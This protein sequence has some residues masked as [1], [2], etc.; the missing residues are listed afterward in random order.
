MSRIKLYFATNRKHEGKDRWHPRSYGKGFSSNGQ[1]NLRFG[2]IELSVNN[3]DVES[4]LTKTYK[5][6]RVGDGEGLAKYLTK[7]A[8]KGK[9]TAYK[10]TIDK[11]ISYEEVPSTIVFREIKAEMEKCSDVL[12]FVHGYNVDWYEAVGSALALEYSLNGKRK[13]PDD[14]D[15]KVVLFSWPSN[16][17]S[18]PYAAYWSDRNDAEQSGLAVGRAMMKLDK[19]FRWLHKEVSKKRE[20]H[21]KQDIHLLCH[22]MGN[23]VLQSALQKLAEEQPGVRLPRLFKHIFMCSADVDDNVLEPGEPMGRLHELALDV[24]VY[25][26]HGDVALHLSDK[27]KGNPD[28]LG[29]TGF[30]HGSLVHKKVH[31][32]DCAPIVGGFVEHS[33]YLWA[34]VNDDISET[35]DDLAFDQ[36]ARMRRKESEHSWVMI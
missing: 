3:R 25:H 20:H 14:K 11:E 24:S 35:I 7:Q 29:Q 32:I 27:T 31:Q 34:T 23:Y 36:P 6:D 33:Y 5:Q 8:K 4:H 15:V 16:G 26:N 17:S 10:D 13:S 18:M 9:I 30:A 2:A 19:F 28:R 21:C 12:I 1:H 22:S